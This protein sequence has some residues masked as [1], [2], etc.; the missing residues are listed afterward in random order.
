MPSFDKRYTSSLNSGSQG[1]H[2]DLETTSTISGPQYLQE[3]HYKANGEWRCNSRQGRQFLEYGLWATYATGVHPNKVT[4]F[5]ED[6]E[7]QKYPLILVNKRFGHELLLL[8][9]S[10]GLK[11]QLVQEFDT[12]SPASW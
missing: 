3:S 8:L 6:H 2:I 9:L 11:L 4:Q 10:A 12:K 5:D 1:S 7:I